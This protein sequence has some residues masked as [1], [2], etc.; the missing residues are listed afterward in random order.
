MTPKTT[1]AAAHRLN[2]AIVEVERLKGEIARIEA[3]KAAADTAGADLERLQ[4]QRTD[5]H[6]SAMLAGRT[7]DTSSLDAAIEKARSSVGVGR[8][9]SA[10]TDRALSMLNEALSKAEQEQS[11]ANDALTAIKVAECARLCNEAFGE[12]K[13]TVAKL[14]VLDAQMWGCIRTAQTL[15]RN[16]FKPGAATDPAGAMY[17]AKANTRL[18]GQTLHFLAP[19]FHA[20]DAPW[21]SP[22]ASNAAASA[23]CADLLT[24]LGDS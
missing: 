15:D 13:T 17:N 24:C 8:T 14:Q 18:T 12:F 7:A 16:V 10:V 11:H 2:A 4:Q 3:V 6:A 5:A 9:Q 23:H 22:D 19:A 21:L 1:T 20:L